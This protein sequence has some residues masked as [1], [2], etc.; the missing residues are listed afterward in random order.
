M[1]TT[2]C[3]CCK[4]CR[5]Y[6]QPCSDHDV[7]GKWADP[8]LGFDRGCW[9]GDADCAGGADSEFAVCRLCLVVGSEKLFKITFRYKNHKLKDFLLLLKLLKP[10]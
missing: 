9:H 7:A 5:D 10:I 8:P 4:A 3:C 1:R 2:D 6:G